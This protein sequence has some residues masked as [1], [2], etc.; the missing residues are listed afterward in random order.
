MVHDAVDFDLE[1]GPN[2]TSVYPPLCLSKSEA[3]NMFVVVV[4]CKLALRLTS[5]STQ[6]VLLVPGFF[7]F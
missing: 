2:I 5:G 1:V 7:A 3:Q 6:C 4:M